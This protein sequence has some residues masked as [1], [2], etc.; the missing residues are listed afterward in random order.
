[1]PF[2]VS[3]RV[4]NVLSSL[5]V[6]SFSYDTMVISYL[7]EGIDQPMKHANRWWLAFVIAG[8]VSLWTLSMVIAQGNAMP[9]KQVSIV[10]TMTCTVC[11]L[12]HPG[13][14]CAPGCCEQCIKNGDPVLFTDQGGNQYVLTARDQNSKLM[15]PER[16]ALLGQKVLVRGRLVKGKG[17]QFIMVESVAKE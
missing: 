17:V 14:K 5:P 16:Y 9:G 4:I 15:I 6:L 3:A 2:G 8:A 10:G 12:M 11:Q 7:L 13:T 1:M